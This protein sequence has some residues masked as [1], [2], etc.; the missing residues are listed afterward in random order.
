MSAF[1]DDICSIVQNPSGT[2][3]AAESQK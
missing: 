1:E 3:K 2:R